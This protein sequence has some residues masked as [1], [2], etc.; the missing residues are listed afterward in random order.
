MRGIETLGSERRGSGGRQQ[1]VVTYVSD[2]STSRVMVF[3]VKVFTK[4]CLERNR[5]AWVSNR[6]EGE[7][8]NRVYG[9]VVPK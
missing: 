5:E 8:R 7:M 3:P 2:G 1:A 4:I 9:G 6:E